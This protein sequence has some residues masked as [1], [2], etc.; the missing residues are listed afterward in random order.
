MSKEIIAVDVDDVLVPH[1][2]DL[3]AWYNREYGTSL[4]LSD[5]HSNDNAVWGTKTEREAIM[6]VE[7]FY[8]T[9]EFLNGQPALEAQEILKELNKRY[10]LIII[11][12]RDSKI[13]AATRNWIDAHFYQLFR[14]VHFTAQYSLDSPRLRKADIC[15]ESG[16]KYLIDDTPHHVLPAAKEGVNGVIFGDYPW[17]QTNELPENVVRCKDWPAVLEY[18]GGRDG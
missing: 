1:F 2:E 10:D 3:I 11:T 12:A 13:E 9:D 4:Q 8:E 5:N 18:F 17:N 16:A 7:R 6:R 14:I 15:L